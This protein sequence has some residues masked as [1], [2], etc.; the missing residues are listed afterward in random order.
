MPKPISI[1]HSLPISQSGI[2]LAFPFLCAFFVLSAVKSAF[3]PTSC[4][5]KVFVHSYRLPFVHRTVTLV[6]CFPLPLKS[7]GC[8]QPLAPT[9]HK[10]TVGYR[11][12]E[13]LITELLPPRPRP[14]NRNRSD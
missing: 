13:R 7:C 8:H 12:C 9:V 1:R 6:F 14:L 2:G 10:R 11:I 3:T 4:S 5:P